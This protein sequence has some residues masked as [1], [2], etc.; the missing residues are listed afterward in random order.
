MQ[1][2]VQSIMNRFGYMGIGFLIFV[3]TV[4][5]PIP[6]EVILTFGGFLT[7]YTEMTAA[8]VI[9]SSAAASLLGAYVLYALG[10][11]MSPG[12]LRG[13]FS[14]KHAKRA[15][16][17]EEEVGNTMD[18]FERKGEK[19]VFFGRCMPIVRSLI[20]VPAGMAGMN[21]VRF[22]VFTLA[23]SLIWDTLLVMLGAAAG[24]SWE[25]ILKYMDAYS[26]L[27]KIGAATAAAV[28]L[29]RFGARR[30]KRKAKMQKPDERK[31]KKNR[32]K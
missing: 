23:G 19:A 12:R 14:G 17:Q 9:L 32:K 1:E 6:S 16:F 31:E 30:K 22:T 13:L 26:A 15:G 11:F 28:I 27:V 25:I 3:E 10:Y 29:M 7:T 24:E 20:S 21:P 8:G 2:L 18:W 5:P 4:F